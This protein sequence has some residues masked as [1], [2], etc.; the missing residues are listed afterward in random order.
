M[1]LKKIQIK[2]MVIFSRIKQKLK[3]KLNLEK[4]PYLPQIC[5][6]LTEYLKEKREKIIS[7]QM[8][9]LQKIRN[10]LVLCLTQPSRHS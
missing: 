6:A 8:Q 10:K 4:I 3:L 9:N 2:I 7:S 5:A 1:K